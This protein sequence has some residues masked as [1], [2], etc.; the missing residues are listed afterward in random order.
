MN[1]DKDLVAVKITITYYGVGKTA[2]AAYA[3]AWNSANNDMYHQTAKIEETEVDIT[4]TNFDDYY[5]KQL[6]EDD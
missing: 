2:A 4:E 3:D 1:N 6:R 5:L